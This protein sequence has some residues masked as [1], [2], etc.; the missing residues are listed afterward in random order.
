[1]KLDVGGGHCIAHC[2]GRGCQTEGFT[3]GAESG[4]H[5]SAYGGGSR[6]QTEGYTKRLCREVMLH[7]LWNCAV[8][9]DL[10]DL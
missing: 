8:E 5:C 3:K 7:E 10:E 4:G 1:M 9:H 6:C 2:G